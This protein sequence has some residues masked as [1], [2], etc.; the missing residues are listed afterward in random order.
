MKKIFYYSL[1]MA[2]VILTGCRNEDELFG[3][4][5]DGNY[6]VDAQLES[7]A[8]SRTAV[9]DAN[10]V[11]WL[12]SDK[13]GV[14][15]DK[16]SS[17][18]AFSIG[19]IS[20]EGASATFVGDLKE[21][22]VATTVYYPYDE[23][24]TLSGNQLTFTLPAEYD[25]TANS[26]APMIGVKQGNGS[27]L[28]K[29][30]CG[31]LKFSIMGIPADAARLIV[32]SRGDAPPLIAGSCVVDDI[33]ANGA[34]FSIKEGFDQIAINMDGITGT[35]TFYVPIPV[36]R[37]PEIQVTLEKQDG[38]TCFSE[39]L[40]DVLVQRATI[41]RVSDDLVDTD[42]S[43]EEFIKTSNDKDIYVFMS[44]LEK[45]LKTN[46]NIYE[47]EIDLAGSEI[48]YKDGS[49]QILI[50]S[51]D[52]NAFKYS[53]PS[54]PKEESMYDW[55][56]DVEEIDGFS[57]ISSVDTRASDEDGIFQ[58][59][60]ILRWAPYQDELGVDL[61]LNTLVAKSPINFTIIGNYANRE[62]TSTRLNDN[63]SEAGI[64]DIETH[65][66]GGE[67]IFIPAE[68][69]DRGAYEGKEVNTIIVYFSRDSR[70]KYGKYDEVGVPIE[71]FERY[72]FCNN[73]IVFNNSCESACGSANSL[74][75]LFMNKGLST[76]TGYTDVVHGSVVRRFMDAYTDE[77]FYNLKSN[78]ESIPDSLKYSGKV[79]EQKIDT[80][81]KDTIDIVREFEAYF[82]VATSK[83]MRFVDFEPE[84]EAEVTET[85]IYFPF[86]L[87]GV[88]NLKDDCKVGLLISDKNEVDEEITNANIKNYATIKPH[89]IGEFSDNANYYAFKG[90]IEHVKDDLDESGVGSTG[91]KYYWICLE[92]KGRYW[93][94]DEY[95]TFVLGDA[96]E[97][98]M[99]EYLVKL[100]HDTD[101]D[102]WERNDNWLSDKP[103]TEWYGVSYIVDRVPSMELEYDFDYPDEGYCLDLDDNNLK[104]AV[105]LSGCPLIWSFS[106]EE[107]E[108]TS[109]DVSNC[110]SLCELLVRKNMDLEK[111]DISNTTIT[112]LYCNDDYF[113]SLKTLIA[114]NS[115][116]H[117]F[118]C[119]SPLEVFQF[120][121]GSVVVAKHGISC[122]EGAII[123]L[124]DPLF[125]QLDLSGS[126]LGEVMFVNAQFSD[127]NLSGC[128][129][130][131]VIR[132][133]N[134]IITNLNVSNCQSIKGGIDV[135]DSEIS[136]FDF[137]NCDGL[138]ELLMSFDRSEISKLN[139]SGC[140]K[141]Y[142]VS[143]DKQCAVSELNLSDCPNLN[144]VLIHKSCHLEALDVS[145]C[146][147]LT[148]ISLYPNNLLTTLDVSTCPNLV[149]LYCPH[150]SLISINASGCSKLLGIDCSFNSLTSLNVSGCSDLRDID[151]SYNQL[152]DL[153][154]SDCVNL[155]E[156]DCMYNKITKEI[157]AAFKR[158]SL[159]YHDR[160][161]EYHSNGTY[162]DNG[163]G[164]WYPGEPESG[165]HAWPDE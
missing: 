26:N 62:A 92:Y 45:I 14:Y 10:Q 72:S 140:D 29:H 9:N 74:K 107:N 12:E 5:I 35:Q 104:G 120:S 114:E 134:S 75:N 36:G 32:A 103:I 127:L 24:A 86:Y 47:Y 148:S 128:Q 111:I 165:K 64:I 110:T 106:A 51:Y 39:K 117:E 22:E 59:T 80:I 108:L 66:N 90:N 141:L 57:L 31:L 105:D 118:T 11:L 2:L 115:K 136:N 158:L 38:T 150:N 147:R 27:F 130:L 40:S 83:E 153:D 157:P 17:N 112:D 143:F 25:Y 102:N 67:Y 116:L 96:G 52:E 49:K 144:D 8:D 142:S 21:G 149:R 55:I 131:G 89:S 85:E 132:V 159:F 41:V 70:L 42:K 113:P 56:A 60:K 163:V 98:A 79:N 93:I 123:K 88:G 68:N 126:K 95:G 164:W 61:D 63:L 81:S 3:Q 77:L 125:N 18:V 87:K 71:A 135:T 101:G 76:Y 19:Q 1:L 91:T 15:G 100:Y 146:I 4:K 124:F 37:Y 156:L 65:G 109:V 129:F 94:S 137:S 23:T 48:I 6:Q 122:N 13:I 33:T 145:R 154:V 44:E 43:V 119:Y 50:F 58:N 133:P 69:I 34:V 161:Y 152:T 151:C 46:E 30:L 139:L 20:D 160:R 99:R 155:E 28:F 97:D 73:G 162:T 53:M 16:G 78:I 7:R 82:N 54:I 84:Q 121:G 138:E